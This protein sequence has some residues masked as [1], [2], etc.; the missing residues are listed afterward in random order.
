MKNIYSIPGRAVFYAVIAF[1]IAACG[2]VE[3]QAT[4]DLPAVG[5]SPAQTNK[6]EVSTKTMDLKTQ[7]E[8]S[9]NDLAQRLGVDLNGIT[10]SE[11]LPVT[12]RSGALG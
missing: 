5:T 11:S 8:F 2:K 6:T 10:L 7:V 4:S 3:N 12:W 1:T 9:R